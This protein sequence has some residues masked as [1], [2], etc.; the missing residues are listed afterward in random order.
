MS[1]RKSSPR[2]TQAEMDRAIACFERL[3]ARLAAIDVRPGRM[4]LISTEGQGLTV[5]ADDAELDEELS[6]HLARHGHAQA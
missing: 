4:R 1:G 2:V 5:G 3:G 6:R